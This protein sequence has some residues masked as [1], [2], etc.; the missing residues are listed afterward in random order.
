MRILGIQPKTAGEKGPSKNK[1][2]QTEGLLW[3]LLLL[4][5]CTFITGL[6]R[7]QISAYEQFSAVKQKYN[8][9]QKQL[10]DLQNENENLKAESVSLLEQKDKLIDDILNEQGYS[11]LAA[12]LEE[13]RRTAGLTDVKGDGVTV[14]L[15]DSTVTDASDLNQSSLIHSQDVQYVVDLLKTAGAEAIAI[16]GERIVCTSVITCT[17]P[18][19]RVNN[20]R[21][22]VPFVITAVC[23][24]DKAMDLIDNDSYLKLRREAK[25]EISAQKSGDL[26][27][28]AFQ[29]GS[30][31]DALFDALEEAKPT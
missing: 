25:V 12:S 9:Y 26:K 28:F 8:T 2:K 31:V 22:P 13:I 24:P 23:D 14:T 18:T 20:N 16:N 6:I 15:N 27:I 19:I 5:L 21:Y 11:E 17:G 30:A 29:D 10:L 1:K 7:N 4:I 3:A